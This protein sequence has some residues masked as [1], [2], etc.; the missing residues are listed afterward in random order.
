MKTAFP[1]AV[2]E[3]KQS[4][5][6]GCTMADRVQEQRLCK[7]ENPNT[8]MYMLMKGWMVQSRRKQGSQ[9]AESL[10]GGGARTIFLPFFLSF[11]SFL[12]FF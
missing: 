3:L 5:R 6:Q 4:G 7:K 10:A 8:G 11:F 12:F 1:A 9:Q 2:T